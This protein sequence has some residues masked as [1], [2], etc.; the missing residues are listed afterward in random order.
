MI[1]VTKL[2]SGTV[3]IGSEVSVRGWVRSKRESKAGICFIALHDGSCFETL[4]IVAPNTLE[5][6]ESEISNITT[7]C[8][9]TISG[10]LSASEGSG[11]SLEIQAE[12]V[13]VVGWVDDPKNYPIAKK[14]HTFEYLRTQAHLRPRT[15]T[16]S[17]ITRIRTTFYRCLVTKGCLIQFLKQ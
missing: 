3:P 6:Y 13:V 5:N 7:G 14:R 11:Q 17:A 8:S 15:N 12:S 1:S 10:K 9:L 16:F 2:L 4:Q